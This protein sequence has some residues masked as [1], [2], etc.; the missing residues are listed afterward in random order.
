[1]KSLKY[2]LYTATLVA[3]TACSSSGDEGTAILGAHIPPVTPPTAAGETAFANAQEGLLNLPT[4]DPAST[5]N[6]QST[7]VPTF[8]SD[9]SIGRTTLR[10][11]DDGQE[12]LTLS[13]NGEDFTVT[14]S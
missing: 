7:E 13:V 2:L 14:N 9:G 11:S 6:V 1:M 12:T 3:L 5:F 10:V 4:F 8:N